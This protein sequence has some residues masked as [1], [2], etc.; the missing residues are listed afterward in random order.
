MTFRPYHSNS[1]SAVDY[2]SLARTVFDV[3]LRLRSEHRVWIHCWD[4]SLELA[5]HLARNARHRGCP[6]LLTVQPEELWL[7]SLLELPEKALE[8]VPPQTAAALGET[9][10]YV[11]TV[12]PPTPLRWA[13]IPEERRR[14]ISIWLD[15]RYDRSPFARS[16]AK[17]AI[18][19]RVRMIGIEATLA[20]P[21][22][23]AALGI[24][25]SA[26]RKV[27]VDGCVAD[28][29]IVAKQARSLASLLSDPVPVEIT[30]PHGTALRFTLDRRPVQVSDGIATEAK[31]AEGRVTYLPAGNVE[32]T[33]IEETAEGRVVLN[34]PIHTGRGRAENLTLQLERGRVTEFAARKGERLFRSFLQEGTGDV[35]R[36]AFFGLGLNP[37]LKFGYT[38]D[39]K[40]L[41]GVTVGLGDNRGKGGRN[42][43]G[44]EWW[45]CIS[46]ATVKIGRRTIMAR[47]KLR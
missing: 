34:V 37:K 47:G 23:A 33:A 28:Y 38:Q 17:L 29:R 7:R 3:S 12:G 18:A 16:W 10:V 22:R 5:F 20:T 32:V 35:D 36:F 27:M 26:W 14:L 4:D 15:T 24:D 41:G 6:T 8:V 9:D 40:V 43:A 39:D 2:G 42:R 45:G 11:F 19:R 46:G 1:L 44:T 25:F 31:A 30:T 21:K 13:R